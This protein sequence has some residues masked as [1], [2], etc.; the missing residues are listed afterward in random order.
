MAERRIVEMN[1][2]AAGVVCFISNYSWLDGLSFT[3]MRERYLECFDR[4]WIDCLNG[5]KYKTGKLT[6][7]GDPDP[8]VFSTDA[9]REGIQVGTAITLLVR[10]NRSSVDAASRRVVSKA[11]E[12]GE[13]AASTVNHTRQ[14][15]AS[16]NRIH[17][18]HLWGKTKRE[19]L[20]QGPGQYQEVMPVPELGLSFMPGRTTAGYT[21]WP[22]LPEL[23][24]VSFPGVKTSR[25]DFVVDVDRTRL[26]ARMQDY[27]N[28]KIGHDELRQ[29]EPSAMTST[30]RFQAEEV[31][32]QLLKRG[33]LP[34]NLVRYCYRPFDMRWLYWEPTTKLL[35]EKRSD[36]FPH[37]GDGN[38]WI[39]ARQ[40]QTMEGFDRGYF[41]RVLADNFGNGLSNFFPLYLHAEQ[42]SLLATGRRPNLSD[43]VATYLAELKATPEDLFYH[44]LAVLHA[45][46]YR[47]E[48]SGA[49][50]QD[51]PRVPLP[52]WGALSAGGPT[53][54]SAGERTRRSASLQTS[55]ALGRRIA[56]LLDT[57]TPVPGVTSGKIRP[58][59]KE[60]GLLTH[61]DGKHLDPDAGDLDLTAGWGHAGKGGVTMPGKGRS[62]RS[63]V[64]G[65]LKAESGEQRSEVGGQSL[66]VFL[67]ANVYWRNIPQPVWEYTLGGYQVIKKWLSY[68][69]KPLLGRPLTVEETRYVTE[70]ARRIAVL[71]GM[72][73]ELDGNYA[74][75]KTPAANSAGPQDHV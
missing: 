32:S 52:G 42:D 38:V 35:D 44:T 68:R 1:Q 61:V 34:N 71:V 11:E 15:A 49:L 17:F 9:N 36:Y 19:Q 14:D 6:P 75:S 45:P 30:Q 27:F 47:T 7:D 69:E 50:R 21:S 70:M 56:A 60:I 59:L 40:R 12:R 55:A 29:R 3:G 4:I 51:W 43:A 37:V 63:E 8:S 66:D 20:L 64:G 2:P 13:D 22:L 5:D 73:G 31:R 23:F 10:T 16:T 65:Q 53:S 54:A 28:Q 58:E 57:D 18:R 46:A 48:N 74:L 62:R 72:A 39:E 33:F 24:P 26:L 67:N 41:V 25:D